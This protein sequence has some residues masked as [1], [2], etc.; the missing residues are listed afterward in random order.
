MR[1]RDPKAVSRLPQIIPSI[2]GGPNHPFTRLL[3][4]PSQTENYRSH[5]ESAD[6]ISGF[7]LKTA[8]PVS[9]VE[10]VAVRQAQA[11]RTR[12]PARVFLRAEGGAVHVLQS[13]DPTAAI[14]YTAAPTRG[15]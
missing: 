4:L 10:S 7:A 8:A 9:R 5:F 13:E 3:T 14:A 15:R 12:A 2:P 6:A 1:N 11:R